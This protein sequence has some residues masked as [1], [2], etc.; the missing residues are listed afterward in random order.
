MYHVPLKSIL[1][2]TGQPILC[3]RG[4][5]LVFAWIRD[6]RKRISDDGVGLQAKK[7][8]SVFNDYLQILHPMILGNTCA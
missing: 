4:L 8:V 2:C 6:G 3:G 5:L 7:E 1:N